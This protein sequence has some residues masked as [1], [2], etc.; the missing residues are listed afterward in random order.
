MR[1][2]YFHALTQCA[3]VDQADVHLESHHKYLDGKL[4]ID[5]LVPPTPQR[6]GLLV[7]FKFHRSL[8]VKPEQRQQN[9]A[10]TT[11]AADLC[12]DFY[13][14]GAYEPGSDWQRLLVYL[15]DDEMAG[16]LHRSNIFTPLYNGTNAVSVQDL[17]TGNTTKSFQKVV[18]GFQT[19]VSAALVSRFDEASL[20]LRVF[21][22]TGPPSVG[23]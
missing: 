12:K 21:E 19:D 14:L 6:Q 17:M 9:S 20:H 7:E 8:S 16:Y 5:L 1:Y 13:R 3:G 18:M 4:E 15:T 22:V 2:A 11:Q 10:R 23:L